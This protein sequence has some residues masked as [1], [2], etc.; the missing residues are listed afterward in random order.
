MLIKV[1]NKDTLI[2]G[3][4]KFKCCVGKNGISTRRWYENNKLNVLGKIKNK[5]TRDIIEK[6]VNEAEYILEK[7]KFSR[8]TVYMKAKFIGENEGVMDVIGKSFAAKNETDQKQIARKTLELFKTFSP[9]FLK[10]LGFGAQGGRVSI[11]SFIRFG[12]T[13]RG[14]NVEGSPWVKDNKYAKE[15]VE[16]AQKH[17]NKENVKLDDIESHKELQIDTD[18]NFLKH[19][20]YKGSKLEKEI[21]G[22]LESNSKNKINEIPWDAIKK[23]NKNAY[24]VIV[25]HNLKLAEL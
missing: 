15:L 3:S 11:S 12:L 17:L 13:T 19:A 22:V 16:G 10:K 24:K 1:K 14:M 4:F 21:R 9:A 25:I 18:W 20:I 7:S 23:H 8:F 6:F 5:K 2:A